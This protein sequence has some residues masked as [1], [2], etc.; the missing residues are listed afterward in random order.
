VPGLFL[1]DEST[2]N[3]SVIEKSAGTFLKDESTGTY[4]VI[5]KKCLDFFKRMKV[6]VLIP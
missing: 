3:Y 5:E 6:H 4:S 1:K 2:S